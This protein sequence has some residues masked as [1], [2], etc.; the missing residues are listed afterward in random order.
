M[1]ASTNTRTN[2]PPVG[3]GARSYQ[4]L[5]DILSTF[6]R[7]TETV[8][9]P[10]VRNG[11]GVLHPMADEAMSVVQNL[12]RHDL[13]HLVS[14]AEAPSRSVAG[15]RILTAQVAATTASGRHGFGIL[16]RV[17]NS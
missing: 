12:D 7:S 15:L 8:P 17:R 13:A 5:L 4:S 3:R 10:G 6:V 9:C 11:L 1:P 16:P 14:I 2:A